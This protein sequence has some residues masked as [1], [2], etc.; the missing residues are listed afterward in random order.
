MFVTWMLPL[1]NVYKL[2]ACLMYMIKLVT[3]SYYKNAFSGSVHFSALLETTGAVL[4]T[5]I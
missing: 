3:F 1:L 4:L 2:L 5:L